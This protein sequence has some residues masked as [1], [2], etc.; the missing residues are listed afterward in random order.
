MLTPLTIGAQEGAMSNQIFNSK[1]LI[2]SD[3]DVNTEENNRSL[4]SM[5]RII[6][7]FSDDIYNKEIAKLALTPNQFTVMDAVSKNNA[8]QIP[9]LLKVTGIERP[10]L[11]VVLLH[12]EKDGFLHVVE[13]VKDL[14]SK[15]LTLTVK[16]IEM[17]QTAKHAVNRAEQRILN[18]L[19]QGGYDLK[20]SLQAAVDAVEEKTALR[21]NQDAENPDDH[22]TLF[23]RGIDE[24]PIQ[25]FNKLDSIKK[26]FDASTDLDVKIRNSSSVLSSTEIQ[27]Q[28]QIDVSKDNTGDNS[29]ALFENITELK[30]ETFSELL[31]KLTITDR[32]DQD[33]EPASNIVRPTPAPLER[34]S[35]SNKSTTSVLEDLENWGRKKIVQ[36]GI[37]SLSQALE[38]FSGERTSQIEAGEVKALAQQF[39]K[40]RIGISPDPQFRKHHGAQRR[41]S[42]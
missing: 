32:S 25:A 5:L 38:I 12:L 2:V 17:L 39:S 22:T 11:D 27:N 36:G 10:V 16:G 18:I 9:I 19:P 40:L 4:F 21:T 3:K 29:Y 23:G 28:S 33:M 15:R 6:L 30:E 7:Q 34:D 24:E 8:I 31:D 13:S 14:S 42:L 26:V 37:I 1:Y 35:S 41:N 20:K